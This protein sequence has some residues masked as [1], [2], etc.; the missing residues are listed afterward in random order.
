MSGGPGSSDVPNTGRRL[1]PHRLLLALTILGFTIGLAWILR[2]FVR[3]TIVLPLADLAWTVWLG[4][5]S[6]HQAIW[7]GLL[8][9]VGLVVTLRSLGSLGRE[10]VRSARSSGHTL[11]TSRYRFWRVGLDG[12][13]YSPFTRERIRHELQGLV[14]QVLAGQNRA[15]TEEVRARLVR[16]EIEL[17]PE[18]AGLFTRTTPLPSVAQRSWDW[19]RWFRRPAALDPGLDIEKIISW[20][21]AQTG[22]PAQDLKM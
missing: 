7:W 9:M 15:E 22:A 3:Q 6:L 14:L 13:T 21:E 12:Q 19:R 11:S 20:L 1:T 5:I 10:P 4:L 17:P 16:G 8:L 18:V 2:D